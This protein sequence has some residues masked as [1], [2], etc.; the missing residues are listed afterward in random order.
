MIGNRVGVLV[1]LIAALSLS[2]S[3]GAPQAQAPPARGQTVPATTQTPPESTTHSVK[4]TL[5]DGAQGCAVQKVSPEVIGALPGDLLVWNVEN[6]CS[7]EATLKI[8]QKK[9]SRP[10]P[11]AARQQL[12]V[13]VSV[14]TNRR[15]R[16]EMQVEEPKNAPEWN[17]KGF[18]CVPA[19]CKLKELPQEICD[20]LDLCVCREPPCP[21]KP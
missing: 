6:A 9:E 4:I 20:K 3:S 7:A 2:S 5:R 12:G 13:S 10:L 11:V 18:W 8:E 19:A 1:T 15:A 16:V 17:E 14:L 21:P